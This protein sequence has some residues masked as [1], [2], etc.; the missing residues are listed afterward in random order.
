MESTGVKVKI[1]EGGQPREEKAALTAEKAGEDLQ[2][3]KD[4]AA[5]TENVDLPQYKA[6]DGQGTADDRAAIES[7][8]PQKQSVP[9]AK[10]LEPHPDSMQ[11]VKQ[12]VASLE[13]CTATFSLWG[14]PWKSDYLFLTSSLWLSHERQ[15]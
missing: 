5:P 6:D 14:E 11:P 3:P 10:P 7:T 15:A 12:E 13:D 8:E 1:P 4:V 9:T 2:S